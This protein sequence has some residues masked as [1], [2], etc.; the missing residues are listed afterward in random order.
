MHKIWKETFNVH[1]YEVDALGR[2]SLPV[3]G[4]LLQEA[5]S[6]HA[7]HLGWGY[8]FL[9]S[10]QYIWVLTALRLDL[11]K[12]PQWN[13]EITIATWPSGKNR[14]YYYR[15]FRIGNK[16]GECLG[17]ATTNWII[18]DV[19]SRR[20]ARVQIPEPIDYNEMENLYE[21]APRKR[22]LSETIEPVETI[23]VRFDDLDI[24]LH[25]NNIRYFDW[26]LRSIDSDYR[27]KHRM[28]MFEIHFLSEA[29]DSD[30]VTISLHRDGHL[31]Q[32]LLTRQTDQKPLTQ[33]VSEWEPFQERI[34]EPV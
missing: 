29:T 18:L 24:N 14:L 28:K 3:I 13:D 23:D 5:A 7:T 20:P 6:R 4:S 17:T 22:P 34:R 9:I 27:R 11:K 33:A 12:D 8:D 15:D 21:S 2:M 25:V 16:Q 26:I 1:T 10:N 31:M 32:H 19:K 30:S